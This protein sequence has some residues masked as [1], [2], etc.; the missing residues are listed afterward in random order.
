M[1]FNTQ[2]PLTPITPIG[3]GVSYSGRIPSSTALMGMGAAAGEAV[4]AGGAGGVLGGIAGFLGVSAGSVLTAGAML[5]PALIGMGL[6][7]FS[8][9]KA[10]NNLE[11]MADQWMSAALMR[12]SKYTQS[13]ESLLNSQQQKY[14]WLFSSV[15]GSEGMPKNPSYD[16]N[17]EKEYGFTNT[18]RERTT[19]SRPR[20]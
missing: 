3:G 4:K 19:G 12:E 18:E 5:I 10:S 1:G 11:D 6:N 16:I 13:I 20:R 15:Y 17:T 8:S 9:R 7:I 2:G 14:D